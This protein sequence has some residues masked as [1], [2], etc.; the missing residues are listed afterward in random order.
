MLETKNL[1]Y[2]NSKKRNVWNWGLHMRESWA[3]FSLQAHKHIVKEHSS[4]PH[5]LACLVHG[6]LATVSESM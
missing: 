6:T 4:D 1:K 3:A 2:K 5:S